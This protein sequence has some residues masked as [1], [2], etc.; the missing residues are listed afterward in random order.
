M[1]DRRPRLLVL[2]RSYWP[3][4]EATGQLL[5]ELCEDLAAQFEIAVIAGQP[6]QNPA[7]IEFRR[8]G[9]A[10]RRGVRIRRVW[11]SRFPKSYLPGK[12]VNLL[13]YLCSA[14][15]AALWAPRPDIVLV[16]TDPPLLAFLG[17]F[18]QRWHR[19]RLVVYLQDIYPDV[20]VA[21]G[22]LPEGRVTGV[23]RRLLAG[24]YRQADRI[25]VLSRDMQALLVRWGL[26][27]KNVEYIPNW[28][29]TAHVRPAAEPNPF[30]VLHELEGRFVVM[31]S[32][33]MGLC[34]RLEDVITAAR[35]LRERPEVLFLLVGD[36]ASRKSLEQLAADLPNVRFLPYQ[37]KDTLA[38]SL[39]AADLHLLPVD[40]R[41]I[42]CLMPS[43][44]YGILAAGRPV[45]A[46]APDD[47]ELSEV[48]RSEGVGRVVPPGQP[49]RLAAAICD[50]L[51][52]RQELARMGAAARRVAQRDYDRPKII[53]RFGRMLSALDASPPESGS[54]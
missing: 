38:E 8:T 45:L 37:P 26:S 48:V 2:N 28:V 7:G 20:A 17:W 11:N 9:W 5:T 53:G 16:E 35:L 25:V 51:G 34:Q 50:A 24:V 47:C 14:F 44:L 18:L 54:P 43:K 4:A 41:V 31:Y 15:W 22:K 21:L 10:E 36:G 30:R 33:N 52:D 46:V 12:A 32:G 27:G 39:S 6:N 3:D 13:S 42:S 23:F 29:D 19:A 49:E 40:P 1:V